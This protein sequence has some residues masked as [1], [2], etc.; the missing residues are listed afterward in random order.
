MLLQRGNLAT[1]LYTTANVTDRAASRRAP[2][3]QP[4]MG[5][6]GTCAASRTVDD[7]TLQPSGQRTTALADAARWR[8]VVDRI[9]ACDD[10]AATLRV[11]TI[12]VQSQHSHDANAGAERQP[13]AAA[14][15]AAAA[16]VARGWQQYESQHSVLRFCK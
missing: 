9:A 11:A 14:A 13:P 6:H 5:V 3:L 7:R 4:P 8:P 16:A 12:R 10:R 1:A 15:A 2:G